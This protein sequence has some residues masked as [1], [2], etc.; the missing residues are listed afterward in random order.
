[1]TGQPASH[2][3]LPDGLTGLTVRGVE[4]IDALADLYGE[5]H[6]VQV[7]AVGERLHAP[8]RTV[9]DAWAQRRET[10]RQWLEAGG[11]VVAA[12][13]GDDIAAFAI[14][15]ITSGYAG[16]DVGAALGEVKDFVVG[17]AW[18]RRGVGRALLG[19]VASEL[20]DR[21]IAHW[22]LNVVVGNDDAVA[23]YRREGFDLTAVTLTGPPRTVMQRSP[24]G[25]T[26]ARGSDG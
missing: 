1:M 12:E 14:V 21:G 18:R 8:A 24:P 13:G 26:E 22:R 5:L 23:F 17:R 20:A 6:V 4:I 10:Y 19:V 25:R 11:F 15:G 16:W 2:E 7:E 3:S 9:A